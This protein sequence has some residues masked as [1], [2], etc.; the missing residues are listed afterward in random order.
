MKLLW[1]ADMLYFK[2]NTISI[3]GMKYIHQQYGPV[4]DNHAICLGI[5]DSLGIIELKEQDIG[6]IVI[7]KKTDSF[8]NCLSKSE[9]DALNRINSHFLYSTAKDISITSHN[10]K[11]YKETLP[12]NFISYE[13][14]FDLKNF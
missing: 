12:L 11:G 8:L 10:E 7:T 2:E 5:I 6:E 1:Y 3:T 14:A 4:P 9:L 13:Y